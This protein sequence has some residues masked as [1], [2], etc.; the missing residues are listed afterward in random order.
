T[1]EMR[2][3]LVDGMAKCVYGGSVENTD[4]N[5]DFDYVMHA[6]TERWLQMGAGDYG[7]MRA[8]MFGRLKFDGP[9]WE[10]MKNMGPFENFLLLVGAV[11]SDASACP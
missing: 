3:S 4:L 2:I 10:A 1:V 5:D 8:M 6:T 7:P 9:K 11:E